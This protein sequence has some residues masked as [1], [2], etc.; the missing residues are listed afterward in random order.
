LSGLKNS[1]WQKSKVEKGKSKKERDRDGKREREKEREGERE[2][3][4]ER[5]NQ[6]KKELL[7]EQSKT[8]I[9]HFGTELANCKV[10]D[11]TILY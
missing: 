10:A 5:K 6:I 3:K 1:F 8:M 9:Y 7:M 2:R 4:M 11:L